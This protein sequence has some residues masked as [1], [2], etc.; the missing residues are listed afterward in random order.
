MKYSLRGKRKTTTAMET[1]LSRSTTESTHG[2]W[3]LE[4]KGSL[5]CWPSQLYQQTDSLPHS[6]SSKWKFPKYLAATVDVHGVWQANWKHITFKLKFL[7][8]HC[9]RS[10]D[11]SGRNYHGCF[12]F[13][14]RIR[15][16]IVPCFQTLPVLIRCKYLLGLG[17]GTQNK[18]FY[19]TSF[20]Q[21]E[22][23]KR[24]KYWV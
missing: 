14:G 22:W 20:W 7:I 24:V 18:D 6:Y 11:R 16:E 13:V 15:C 3:T 17:A 4:S 2:N 21:K 5:S 23:L 19:S 1:L 9:F 8:T 12:R 10:I